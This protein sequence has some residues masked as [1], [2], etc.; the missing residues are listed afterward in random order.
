MQFLT[1]LT[2][3]IKQMLSQLPQQNYQSELEQYISARRPQH[4][5]D[6]EF[7]TREYQHRNYNKG[8]L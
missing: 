2:N 7:Y 1:Q 6:V 5:A 3:S 4:A 8:W